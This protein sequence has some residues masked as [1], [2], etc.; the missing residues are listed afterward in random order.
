MNC[1]NQGSK[2]DLFQYFGQFS[3]KYAITLLQVQGNIQINAQKSARR[4]KNF[5]KLSKQ[6][7]NAGFSKISVKYIYKKYSDIFAKIVC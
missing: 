4:L 3:E 2:K 7:Q 6:P 5:D 1:N